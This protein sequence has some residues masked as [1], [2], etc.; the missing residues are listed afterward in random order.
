MGL[1]FP[2]SSVG[3]PSPAGTAFSVAGDECSRRERFV[4]EAEK[5]LFGL[6]FEYKLLGTSLDGRLLTRRNTHEENE[7]CLA[8]RDSGR[9]DGA[10][11]PGRGRQEKEGQESGRRGACRQR[12]V[13][14]DG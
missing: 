9:F 12:R 11:R 2:H 13:D 10:S 4:K 7:S 1:R 6:A 3:R 5:R 14:R 8:V